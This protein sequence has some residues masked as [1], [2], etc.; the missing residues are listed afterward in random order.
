MA[1]KF[2]D[3]GSFEATFGLILDDIAEENKEQAQKAVRAATKVGLEE[4]RKTPS[5]AG[6]FHSWDEYNAGW[7]A[8]YETNLTGDTA[9]IISQKKGKAN[10]THLLEKGHINANGKGRAKAYPH[11]APAADKAF[12]ELERRLKRNE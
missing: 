10:L 5:G 12:D 9:A 2:A 11:V 7:S 1:K 4:V 8:S 3:I 6:K